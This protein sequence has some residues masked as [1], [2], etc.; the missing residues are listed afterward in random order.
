MLKKVVSEQFPFTEEKDRKLSVTRTEMDQYR[1]AFESNY[2]ISNPDDPDWHSDLVINWATFKQ[3]IEANI[4]DTSKLII[5]LIHCYDPAEKRWFLK[6]HRLTIAPPAAPAFGV[7]YQCTDPSAD[8]LAIMPDGS[9]V[10]NGVTCNGDQDADYFTNVKA[11]DA[12]GG[13][14]D[15]AK[16]ANA[17][18]FPW[19][20][21]LQLQ[22]KNNT[23]A[24][25]DSDFHI[26]LVSVSY[27]M[28][29]AM[30]PTYPES[31]VQ[32]PHSIAAII[33][34]RGVDCLN[35]GNIVL[36]NNAGDLGGICPPRCNDLTWQLP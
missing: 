30:N 24:L 23:A 25:P 18:L 1:S 28:S 8:L 20:E 15:P 36:V 9:I 29:N 35:N 27:D 19:Q 26:V 16:Y 4:A 10:T 3:D 31:L 6:V 17:I 11:Q 32:W 13:Q 2:Y 22:S 34:R 14:L 21:F 12:A 33:R 7:S 5:K